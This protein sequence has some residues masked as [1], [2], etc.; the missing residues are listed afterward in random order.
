MRNIYIYKKKKEGGERE[1][2]GVLVKPRGDQFAE[3]KKVRNKHKKEDP[4]LPPMN[5]TPFA[6]FAKNKW[7][8][9]EKIKKEPQLS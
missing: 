8:K 5:Q 4:A 2:G 1:G 6:V 7:G 9:P 3:I